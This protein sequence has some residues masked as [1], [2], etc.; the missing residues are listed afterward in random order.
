MARA[1]LADWLGERTADATTHDN[2]R[3]LVTELVSNGVRHAQ[4]EAE[5]S[6]RLRVWT[7]GTLLHI[8]VWDAGTLGT[9]APGTPRLE[10]GARTGGFGLNLISLLSSDWGVHRDARGTTVWLELGTGAP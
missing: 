3:L 10:D 2:A 5:Q 8:E 1:A 7:R 9:V 6:L 4:I